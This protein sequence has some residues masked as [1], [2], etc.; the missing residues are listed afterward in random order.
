M[1]T[2][3]LIITYVTSSVG[4]RDC[5]IRDIERVAIQKDLDNKVYPPK[6]KSRKS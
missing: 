1:T 4:V 3:S 6:I 5:N 2:S